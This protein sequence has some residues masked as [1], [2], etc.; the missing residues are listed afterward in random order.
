M[1]ARVMGLDCAS[2]RVQARCISSQRHI[3]TSPSTSSRASTGPAARKTYI[4]GSLWG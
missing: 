4:L 1:L 3:K 2:G